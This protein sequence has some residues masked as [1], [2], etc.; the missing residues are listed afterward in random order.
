MVYALSILDLHTRYLEE[1]QEVPEAKQLESL[2]SISPS[3]KESPVPTRLQGHL[4]GNLWFTS[5]QSGWKHKFNSIVSQN[6]P[7]VSHCSQDCSQDKAKLLTMTFKALH[8]LSPVH[9]SNH[10]LSLSPLVHYGPATLVSISFLEHPAFCPAL[11]SSYI[12]VA[13]PG[14]LPQ[15]SLNC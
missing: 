10:L 6:M 11:M 15:Y 13:R 8:K 3:G 12:V 5:Q 1:C 9:L 2:Q 14:M 7:E 4:L